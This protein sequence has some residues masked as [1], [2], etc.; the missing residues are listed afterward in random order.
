MEVIFAMLLPRTML[1]KILGLMVVYRTRT[2]R[3]S[4]DSLGLFMKCRCSRWS[5]LGNDMRH[6]HLWRV[7]PPGQAVP[8]R[9]EEDSGVAAEDGLGLPESPT[10]KYR[11]LG[12]PPRGPRTRLG[13]GHVRLPWATR[14]NTFVAIQGLQTKEYKA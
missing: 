1:P 11:C 10:Y 3:T 4:L 14:H 5:A 2:L 6:A 7:S 12:I 9:S 13:K 8:D